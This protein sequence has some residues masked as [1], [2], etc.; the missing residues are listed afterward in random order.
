MSGYQGGYQYANVP[1][2]DQASINDRSNTNS[3]EAGGSSSPDPPSG[4]SY[5]PNYLEYMNTYNQ[6][7]NNG[8]IRGNNDEME[9]IE[10]SKQNRI[11]I[12]MVLGLFFFM[13]MSRPMSV[14]RDENP[15]SPDVSSSSSGSHSTMIDKDPSAG[16]KGVPGED[17]SFLSGGGSENE[18]DGNNKDQSKGGATETATDVV[19]KLDIGYLLTYP[20][21]GTT[22]TRLLYSFV[23]T[24]STATNYERDAITEDN[25]P[26][27]VLGHTLE[28]ASHTNYPYW[29][30]HVQHNVDRPILTMTH[31]CGYCQY[32][33]KMDEYVT[34][35]EVFEEHCRMI[36]DSTHEITEF[37]SLGITPRSDVK[38]VVHLIRDPL[39]NIVSRFH[40]DNE[41]ALNNQYDG[42]SKTGFLQWCTLMDDDPKLIAEL[43]ETKLITEEVKASMKDL[44]CRMEFY[45][46]VTW[47]NH[48]ETMIWERQY[49]HLT[50][51]F[52]NYHTAEGR[53]DTANSLAEFMDAQV[54]Q[55]EFVPSFYTRS[56]DEYFDKEQKEKLKTFVQTLAFSSTW[57]LLERY[58]V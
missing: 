44:P 12:F 25:Q 51:Y 17:H 58:F 32:P 18:Q 42:K 46:Y 50:I 39:S 11:K 4:N 13:V 47:H 33:C 57:K 45:K 9:V 31:C 1:N 49:P 48:V 55:K 43:E 30:D 54:P 6:Y 34:T 38:K 5:M 7:S 26:V 41:Y 15:A 53:L 21:S 37:K 24:D 2:A 23:T 8:G 3:M 52:E 19:E 10:R 36:S 29:N 22:F 27:S 35:H 40:F 56:Y 14:G 20:M 16:G 28:V